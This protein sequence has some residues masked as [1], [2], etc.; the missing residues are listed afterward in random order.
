[1]PGSIGSTGPQRV[2]KGVRMGGH[3]GGER[4]T[5]TNL[6]VVEVDA[7]KNELYVRGAVPGAKG[8]LLIIAGVGDMVTAEVAA[9][10]ALVD[11]ANAEAI[12]EAT[13]ETSQPE[14]EPTNE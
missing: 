4:V 7:E 1:M 11:E 2:F 13:P 12:V 9:P 14:A 6:E 10:A 3:M 8:G 5:I